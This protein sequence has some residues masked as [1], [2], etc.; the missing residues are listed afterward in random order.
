MKARLILLLLA[1]PL[2]VA[3]STNIVIDGGNPRPPVKA[4]SIILC[5]QSFNATTGYIGPATTL[6]LGAAV[7]MTMGGAACDILDSTTEATADAPISTVFP[8]FSVQGM[9]CVLSSDPTSDVV[10]TARSAAADLAPTMTCTIAGTGT[11]TN[12]STV[13]TNP[14]PVAAAATI[15][16]KVVTLENLSAQDVWCK[17]FFTL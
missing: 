6:Y 14:A 13:N 1:I 5:G 15:A 17:L 9:F 2:T 11:A 4:D 10:V 3:G 8:A 7:D 16:I 12:C